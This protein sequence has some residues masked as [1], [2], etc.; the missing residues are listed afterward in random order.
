M[1]HIRLL[2]ENRDVY[3]VIFDCLLL[4]VFS[5]LI[6]FLVSLLL[7]VLLIMLLFVIVVVL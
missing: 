4:T 7:L 3:V 6:Q 2:G 5:H 1:Y